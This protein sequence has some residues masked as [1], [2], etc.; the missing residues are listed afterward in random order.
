MILGLSLRQ[1]PVEVQPLARVMYA[2]DEVAAAA[3]EVVVDG[4]GG[5]AFW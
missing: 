2:P 1:A 4:A 3:D 5:A